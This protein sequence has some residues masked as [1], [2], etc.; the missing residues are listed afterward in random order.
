MCTK[1]KTTV[2]VLGAGPGGYSAAFRCA[3]LG[4][5][6]VLIENNLHLGGVCLNVGCIPS[7]TLLHIAHIIEETNI[8]NQY[9]IMSHDVNFDIEK[10]QI[11]KNKII[12]KLS[13]GL[14]NLAKIRKIKI[15]HGYGKFINVNTI[16]VEY[17]N[18]IYII[19]FD[20]A[21]I[22]AGSHPISLPL[23]PNH[24]AR[25][26]NSTDALSLNIIPKRLLIIGGGIIGLEIATIYRAFKVQIDI[27][28]MC[29]QLLPIV[30]RD[31]IEIFTKQINAHFNI[32][33]KTKI[34]AIDPQENGIYVSLEK[35]NKLLEQ[36]YY[37]AVLVAIGRASNGKLLD[38]NRLGIQTTSD[39][40]IHVNNQMQT[41]IP[42]I[43]A[44]GDIIGPPMLA[45]KS[46]YQGRIAAEVISGKKY[47]FDPRV[48][49]SIAYTSPEVAWV[50]IT[51]KEAQQKGII[52][53]VAIFPWSASG[54][55]ISS[56][57]S[58]GM[59]KLIFNKKNNRIIG[60]SVV[61]KHASELLGEISLSI[62]MGCD[63]ADI[64]LTMHA[65]PT[66]YESIGLA[67]EI[68]EGTITDLLNI[69]K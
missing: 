39:G 50:G 29:D 3:D 17:E 66:L 1:I 68:H 56:N 47:Y 32:M 10:I 51:E 48:I 65:H 64:A 8:L 45:H 49:P 18:N 7:K 14:E 36:K 34:I 54:R 9:G 2:V 57:C 26:W 38:I 19:T 33:L 15:I 52:Y 63:A 59:T 11:Y 43:Y 42:H 24:D 16:N 40:F 23:I 67:A 20:Y 58:C 31:V 62:E 37:D 61:G 55:A 22:A 60:G 69:S 13:S 46:I 21:I 5:E 44:I 35:E 53:N 27:V 12:N 25:I 28:E 6:T 41:N 4:L 30:D